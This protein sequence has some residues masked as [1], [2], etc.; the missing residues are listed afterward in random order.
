MEERTMARELE[1][2]R[3]LCAPAPHQAARPAWLLVLLEGLQKPAIINGLGILDGYANIL[4]VR[5][6]L[7]GLAWGQLRWP[8][9]AAAGCR[10]NDMVKAKQEQA[11][12]DEWARIDHLKAQQAEEQGASLLL[13]KIPASRCGK[14]KCTCWEWLWNTACKRLLLAITAGVLCRTQRRRRRWCTRRSKKSCALGL[15]PKRLRPLPA[16]CHTSPPPSPPPGGGT[17]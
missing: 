11:A 3:A 15:R 8:C 16:R 7:R 2:P 4:V 17:F 13:P 9:L 10:R 14:G 12:A 6:P 5:A 1:D